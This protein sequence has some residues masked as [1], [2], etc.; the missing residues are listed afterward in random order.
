MNS[1]KNKSRKLSN[2]QQVLLSGATLIDVR[3]P[4]EFAQGSLPNATNLPL[5]SNEERHLVGTTYKQK[6]QVAAIE[7]GHQL[8][9]GEIKATRLNQWKSFIDNNPGS[10][11]Y[12]FRGGLRSHIVQEWLSTEGYEVALIDGGYKHVRQG[13][14][15]YLADSLSQLKFQVISG[16][17]GVGKT[18]LIKKLYQPSLDLEEIACHRGSAFGAFTHRNQPSQV[19]FENRIIFELLKLKDY[20]GVISVENESRMIGKNVIPLNLFEKIKKS[21]SIEINATMHDRVERIFVEYILNS[22][23]GSD[24]DSTYFENLQKSLDAIA[25][26]LG[27]LKYQELASDL[28][29]CASAFRERGSLVENKI[30]IQKLL[31]CYYDPMYEFSQRGRGKP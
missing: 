11:I 24:K 8:V 18:E 26:K 25:K 4:V 2:W 15:S 23:L 16:R 6:G 31:E 1:E 14:L 19:D 10:I 13:L 29:I 20:S 3:A 17:T 7:L 22:P 27:G 28:R 21:P 30:W 12:C 5:L 9:S